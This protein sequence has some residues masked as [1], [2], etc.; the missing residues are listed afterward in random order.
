M[1]LN[2]AFTTPQVQSALNHLSA[3]HLIVSGETKLTRKAPRSNI[4][5]IQSLIPD[6]QSSR[7]II[8]SESVPSLEG[9][10]VV[11]NSQGR[12]DIKDIRAVHRYELLLGAAHPSETGRH[13]SD[14]RLKN[15]EPVNIQFTSGTTSMPKAAT[16][17]HRNILNNGKLIGDRMLLTHEDV[18]VCPPPLFHCFG[19]ILGYMATATHGSA[20]VF[21]SEAFNA[22]A[23]LEA[24]RDYQATALYGVPTMFIEELD[25]IKHGS[26]QM[27]PGGFRHLRTGIAAGSSIPA[28]LMRKLHK[29]LNLTELTI[30]YGMTETSPV[31]AQT[32]TDDPMDKRIDSVGRALPHT[33]AKVVDPADW[34][35]VLEV[36]ERGELAVS[37]YLVMNGY[38][39]DD[40]KT[41]DVLQADEEGNIWMH[42]GDEA[43]IDSEG[44]VR[45][46]GR[47]KDLIIRGGEN[48]HPLE[49]ENCLLAHDGVQNA[50]VVG[51]PDERYGDVVAAFVVKSDLRD[52]SADEIR[53]W[54]RNR[55]SHQS[56]E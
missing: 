26:F 34:S 48:I 56:G 37:G 33:W 24:V 30:C 6:L 31:S 13:L 46:T 21:P 9:V 20:I 36:G 40:Q 28:E 41:A 11:D 54:V 14:Q 25:L 22:Q 1:P 50:S 29:Q 2:P 18:V 35:R 17:T 23:S 8:Q 12:I 53:D 7:H 49:I 16:L 38:W 39:G 43:A 10:T 32:T 47:I 55:L 51:V 19:C 42:T 3:S 52:V 27:P 15:Y 44:Y 45:I 5:L 4:P